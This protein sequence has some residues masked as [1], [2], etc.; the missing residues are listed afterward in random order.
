MDTLMMWRLVG[1]F[2][3]V[4]ILSRAAQWILKRWVSNPYKRAALVFVIVAAIDF[5]GMWSLYDDLSTG[6]YV[7]L[8]YYI[9]LLLIWLLKDIIDEARK[10]KSAPGPAD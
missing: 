8:F 1:A 3:N 10:K 2:I 5:L 9:P 7:V 4:T 6:A